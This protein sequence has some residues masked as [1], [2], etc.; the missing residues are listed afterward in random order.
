MDDA[1]GGRPQSAEDDDVD[2]YLLH[3]AVYSFASRLVPLLLCLQRTGYNPAVLPESGIQTVH[4]CCRSMSEPNEAIEVTAP[5][6]DEAIKQAL[7]QLGASEDDVIIHVLSTPRSGVLGLG[8]RQARVRVERRA[9]EGASS[10]VTSPPPA[11]P[12]A[13]RGRDQQP[14]RDR[15]EPRPREQRREPPP[16]PS[17]SSSGAE[18]RGGA[19]NRGAEA[20]M[21]RDETAAGEDEGDA[22]RKA[23]G[24]DEQAREASVILARVLELMG[25]GSE[26]TTDR[27]STRL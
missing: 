20:T 25:E 15:A 18:K 24:L 1:Q 19:P 13:P 14:P 5:S 6:V 7:D 27:K 16:P 22:G 23:V 2:A 21:R 17:R 3:R 8:A 12:P 10:G 4:P 11:P 9:P 26:L